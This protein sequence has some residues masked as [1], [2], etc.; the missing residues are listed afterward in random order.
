MTQITIPA[1]VVNG[2]LE[3][4]QSLVQL[5]GQCVLATLTVVPTKSANG[6]RT[7]AVA[8]ARN[9]RQGGVRSRAAA[10]VGGGE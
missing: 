9:R 1:Q 6:K 4:E 5:E 3:H 10:V 7:D 2:H 8:A